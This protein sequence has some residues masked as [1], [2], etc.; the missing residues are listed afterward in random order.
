MRHQLVANFLGFSAQVLS[1]VYWHC[2]NLGAAPLSF[3]NPIPTPGSG[4]WK[5]FPSSSL[6]RL[7]GVNDPTPFKWPLVVQLVVKSQNFR[8]FFLLGILLALNWSIL[9][10]LKA[11]AVLLKIKLPQCNSWL[12]SGFCASL[13]QEIMWEPHH[14][15]FD[16]KINPKCSTTLSRNKHAEVRLGWHEFGLAQ[17]HRFYLAGKLQNT[18]PW[19]FPADLPTFQA[20]A[21]K[22]VLVRSSPPWRTYFH[23]CSYVTGVWQRAVEM[24]FAGSSSISLLETSRCV[25]VWVEMI[26]SL[27]WDWLTGPRTRA[28]RT[29]L[30]TTCKG[31]AG[32]SWAFL[33]EN[34]NHRRQHPRR[35]AYV[36]RNGSLA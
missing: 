34:T 8:I 32:V 14:L 27:D 23:F 15:Q 35:D 22:R 5:A 24:T 2:C 9:H 6:S 16:V 18:F 26:I 21:D 20:S 31:R 13:H 4:R 3:S 12:G 33:A 17:F 29:L 11:M 1:S 30:R 28:G 7:W 10:P 19:N 36:I 25:Q